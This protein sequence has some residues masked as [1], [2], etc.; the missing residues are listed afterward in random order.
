MGEAALKLEQGGGL[1]NL[2]RAAA[3]KDEPVKK[4]STPVL[5][6]EETVKSLATEAR[7]AKEQMDSFKT[8]FDMKS[9]EL[10]Q[11][12]DTLRV[13]LCRKGYTSAVK[14]PTLDNLSVTVV[15]SGNYTK[16]PGSKEGEIISIVG[17]RYQDYFKSQIAIQ[18]KKDLSNEELNDL[19]ATL[20]EEKFIRYFETEEVLRPTERFIHEHPMFDQQTR[21]ALESASVKQYKPSIRT[22]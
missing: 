8:I 22:R 5:P 7:Q 1:K 16:I 14:I 13:E 2:L 12:I 6:V 4:S 9:A 15:W 18:A 21:D 3:K 20:G 19:V 11:A 17:D 10:I